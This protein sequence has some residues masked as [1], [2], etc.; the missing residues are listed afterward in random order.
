MIRVED[1]DEFRAY[2]VGLLSEY[3]C[4]LIELG[5]TENH[6]HI[7][8]V[9]NKKL[10]VSEIVGKIKS[11]TS[12]WFHRRHNMAFAWQEGYGAFSVSQSRVDLVKTYIRNQKEHHRLKKFEEE[13]RE[14]LKAY[15]IDWDERY[16]WD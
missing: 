14:F 2:L 15:D 13:F 1:Y 3:G 11:N 8:F 9:L 7:L 4:Y 10:S 6:V 12:R 5:G 16:V